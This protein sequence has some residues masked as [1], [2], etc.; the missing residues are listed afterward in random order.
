MSARRR[1]ALLCGAAFLYL[2]CRHAY[3]VG[4]FNDDAFYIIGARS[5]LSGRYAELNAPLAPPLVN[6]LPGFSLLLSPVAALAGRALWPYQAASAALLL[7][8]LWWFSSLASALCPEDAW[9]ALALAAFTPLAVS[10]SW[11]VLSDVPMLA[12]AMAALAWARR[13]WPEERPSRWLGLAALVGF[14]ALLRPTGAALALAFALALACERRWALSALSASCAAAWLLPFLARNYALTGHALLYVSELAAPYAGHGRWSI[15]AGTVLLN[16]AYYLRLVF[17]TMLFRW[18]VAAAAGSPLT[19][20]TVGLGSVAAATGLSAAG[21][22]GWAKLPALFLVLFLAAH[23]AWSKQA[24]R[25]L[26]PVL[27]LAFAYFLRG[28][29]VLGA[30]AGASRAAAP[31]AAILALLLMLPTDLRVAEASWRRDSSVTRPPERTMAWVRG[32]TA[33]SDVFAVELDG[34]FYLLTGR[35][36]LHLRRLSG[37]RAFARW[38]ASSG[39]RYVAVF[40]DDYALATKRGDAFDDPLPAAVLLSWLSDPA[41]YRLDFSDP[42]ER[43]AIY[44]RLGR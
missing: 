29:R 10:M 25:Y 5:L 39:A 37:P 32:H 33:P 8:G 28:V 4:F 36:A 22:K 17:E 21:W 6:Y 31:A 20:A 35:R 1:L 12:A 7:A 41:R 11:T 40:P 30:R 24:A 3:Y 16:L 27:P 2:L 18:P 38:L 34:R 26:L 44:E 43:S 19:A 13:L 9:A 42:A 14:A 15:L 23:L